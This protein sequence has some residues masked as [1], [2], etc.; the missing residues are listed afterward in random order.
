MS[1]G[2]PNIKELRS[3][4]YDL[5]KYALIHEGKRNEILRNMHS[6]SPTELQEIINYLNMHQGDPC[7]DFLNP[8]KTA[9]RKKIQ[10]IV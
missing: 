1:W 8:S 4:I 2:I 9:I 10:R 6:E 7:R 3:E 5:L